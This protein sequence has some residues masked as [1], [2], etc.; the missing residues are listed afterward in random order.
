MRRKIDPLVLYNVIFNARLIGY[1]PRQTA[2]L[3]FLMYCVGLLF[4]NDRK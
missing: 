4:G 1:S 3:L 2:H